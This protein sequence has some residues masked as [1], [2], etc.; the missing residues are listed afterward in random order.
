LHLPIASKSSCRRE[1]DGVRR[2]G[3]RRAVSLALVF[4][5]VVS[6]SGSPVRQAQSKLKHLIFIM[7]ENRSFDSYFGTFPGADGIPTRNGRLA[8]CVPD[9]KSRRCVAP[10]HDTSLVNAGGPHAQENAVDDV[11]GGAMNGFVKTLRFGRFAFCKT[12]PFDPACSNATHKQKRPDVMGYHDAREIPNY[13]TYAERFVL[14]DRMFES[15]FSWSLPSHLFVVSGWSA[16]CPVPN[17]A[18][19]CSSDLNQPGHPSGTK[20]SL[21]TPYAWTDLTW[22]MHE[23]NVSWAY[24]VAPGTDRSCRLDRVTCITENSSRNRGTPEIWNPLPSF[25]TVHQDH[26][27]GNIQTTDRFLAAARA[28]TLPAVSWIEPDGTHSEHPPNSIAKGQAYVTNLINAVMQG[29]DWNSS[30]IV[31]W[32]DWGGFYD[33]V[34]PPV[35]DANGYGLRVPGLLISPWAKR[36]YIDHQTLSFDAYLKLIEDIFLNAE[37]L[38][39]TTDGRP[40]PRPIVRENVPILGDL[41]TEFDFSQHP[42]PALVLPTNPPPGP[43]STPG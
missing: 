40:D 19:S 28:G 14:Q 27:I 9:P 10:F 43:A 32:D 39:P 24:Y 17:D 42:L 2:R 12:Y 30:A 25:D 16:T 22:L 31:S 33:H 4:A 38:D 1:R 23:H 11:A 7:Q 15:A 36:G 21:D 26:Q 5:V 20:A 35:V 8:V 3:W 18:S 34:T 41:L 37:R 13:W 6:C 29:P